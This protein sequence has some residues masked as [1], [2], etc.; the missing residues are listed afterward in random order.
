MSTN[1]K[2]LLEKCGSRRDLL[3]DAQAVN[4][5]LDLYAVHRWFQ[6]GSVP[7]R[8]WLSIVEGARNRGAQVSLDQIA[9]AHAA[10][11]AA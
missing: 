11:R 6:R 7:A 3:A 8:Y 9:K 1:I 4:P 10:E 5:D 2:T